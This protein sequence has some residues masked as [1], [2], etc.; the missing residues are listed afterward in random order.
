MRRR[1]FGIVLAAVS[2]LLVTLFLLSGVHRLSAENADKTNITPA[3]A[4]FKE[5][6][7]GD[8][9]V[10]VT[11]A[12]ALLIFGRINPDDPRADY[13]EKST[14]KTD[15]NLLAL[16]YDHDVGEIVSIVWPD[17]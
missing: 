10:N 6:F 7:N 15:R 2:L 12:I 3:A 5:D 8:G 11:D 9:K 16:H 1:C 14:Y 17:N 4:Q 13:N